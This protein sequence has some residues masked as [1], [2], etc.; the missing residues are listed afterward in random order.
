VGS[1]LFAGDGAF[2]GKERVSYAVSAIVLAKI[3]L[4]TS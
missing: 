1:N 3:S 2:L 4:Q